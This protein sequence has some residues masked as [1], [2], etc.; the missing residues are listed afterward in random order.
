MQRPRRPRRDDGAAAVEFALVSVLLLTLLFGIIQYA[1]FFFQSQGASST[2]REA[3]RLAAVGVS[4]CGAF[5]SAVLGRAQANGT[6]IAA[7][8]IALDMR[9]SSGTP[10]GTTTIGDVAVVSITW[11]PQKFGFPFVPFLDGTMTA[12]AETRVENVTTASVTSC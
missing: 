4:S 5:E 11:T 7:P 6:D 1:Y 2:A 3:A 10:V 12:D 8:D 9:D